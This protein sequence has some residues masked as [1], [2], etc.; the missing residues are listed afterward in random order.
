MAFETERELF[1]LIIGY[2]VRAARMRKHLSQSEVGHGLGSQSMISLIE[3][4]KQLPPADVLAKL[5]ER[6]DEPVL[7]EY[8]PLLESGQPTVADLSAS[9]HAILL[10]MLR[11][12]RARWQKI[13]GQVAIHLCYHY[14]MNH[15]F[16]IVLELAG[17]IHAHL[18]NIP[19]LHAEACYLLGSCHLH[20]GAYAE[21]ETFLR[22]AERQSDALSD[23]VRGRLMY[24]LGYLYTETHEQGLAM[25]YAKMAMDIFHR[26]LDFP[27]YAKALG[28][29]GTIQVRVDQLSDARDTLLRCY[30]MAEKWGMSDVDKGRIEATLAIL[31]ARLKDHD[32]AQIWVQRTE[33]SLELAYD[34]RNDCAL[35]I[36]R[37]ELHIQDG[38]MA[39]A[40]QDAHRAMTA[41]ERTNDAQVVAQT[42]LMVAVHEEDPEVQLQ[43]AQKA[44]EG[45]LNTSRNLERAIAAELLAI[46]YR[47]MQYTG[48]AAHY[49]RAALQAY[50]EVM[51]TK[52]VYRKFL[53]VL[54]QLEE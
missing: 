43:Y 44:Y 40:R 49:Q 19:A 23:E 51:T 2:R 54:A 20:L 48:E 39:L 36:A 45:T 50:R 46:L 14:Y 3:S 38:N 6:L 22:S 32:E 26:I 18:A 31:H 5:A 16:E 47:R 12:R 33:Q 52:S 42:R 27:R 53:Q 15:Q 35:N 1:A 10:E 25:Y 21:A 4:G 29:L 11:T 9:N 24:N 34:E 8:V 17:L 37:H 7:A 13:H 28:L 30:E 41:A